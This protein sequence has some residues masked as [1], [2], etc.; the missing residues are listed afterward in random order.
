M[1]K[2]KVC[3]SYCL[4]PSA[5]KMSVVNLSVNH[6]IVSLSVACGVVSS[7][8]LFYD[9]SKHMPHF[10]RTM[11]ME[12]VFLFRSTFYFILFYFPSLV[13]FATFFSLSQFSFPAA[14]AL[15]CWALRAALWPAVGCHILKVGGQFSV[16]EMQGKKKN[17][18]NVRSPLWVQAKKHWSMKWNY[19]QRSANNVQLLHTK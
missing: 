14:A 8:Y 19:L 6:P 3:F 17:C 4:I 18:G 11:D 12:L 2:K 10:S 5:V 9:K 13:L 16:I 7:D 15:K 1:R